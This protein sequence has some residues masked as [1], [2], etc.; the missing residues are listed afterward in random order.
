MEQSRQGQARRGF[1]SRA[2]ISTFLLVMIAVMIVRDILV[3]RFSS[4]PPTSADVTR[5]HQ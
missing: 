2:L 5:R 1:D 3:R 4:T